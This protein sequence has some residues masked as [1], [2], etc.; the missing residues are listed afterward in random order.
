MRRVSVV[1][2]VALASMLAGCVASAPAP[3]YAPAPPPPRALTVYP[4]GGQS[5]RQQD[6][7]KA[8]C[9]S[10]ASRDASSSDSWAQLFIGCM[11]GR[12]YRVE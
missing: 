5:Q 8:D 1:S 3:V 9:Q 12:G 7:D 4:Q 2:F 11:G 10:M 6:R